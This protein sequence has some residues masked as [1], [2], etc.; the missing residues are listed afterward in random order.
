MDIMPA[1]VATAEART[2]A[3]AEVVPVQAEAE[4]DRTR[5]AAA[6]AAHQRRAQAFPAEAR[7]VQAHRAVPA[8][9]LLAPLAVALTDKTM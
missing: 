3:T 7:P 6:G 4:A 9:V 2:A 1:T 8:V 5:A